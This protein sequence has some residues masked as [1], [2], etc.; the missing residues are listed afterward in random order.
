MSTSYTHHETGSIIRIL[1][2]EKQHEHC[3]DEI[4]TFATSAIVPAI[5]ILRIS[6]VRERVY[7]RERRQ[8][9]VTTY[10]SRFS[11]KKSTSRYDA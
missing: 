1:E 2:L 6:D 10:V 9:D 11:W 8:R 3:G 7:E 4:E 5:Q